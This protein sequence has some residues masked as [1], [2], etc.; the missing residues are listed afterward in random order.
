[1]KQVKVDRHKDNYYDFAKAA[2]NKKGD[3]TVHRSSS[4]VEAAGHLKAGRLRIE[5]GGQHAQLPNHEVVQDYIIS[6]LTGSELL[7]TFRSKE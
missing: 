7:H 4:K 3:G 6:L 1:M 2:E 5:L